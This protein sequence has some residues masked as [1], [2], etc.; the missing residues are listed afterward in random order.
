MA[1]HNGADAIHPGYGFLSGERHPGPPLPRRR[2][3]LRRAPARGDGGPRRQG[4][5]QGSGPAVPG[6]AD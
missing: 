3:H 1:K 4:A 5:R 2:H 6:S